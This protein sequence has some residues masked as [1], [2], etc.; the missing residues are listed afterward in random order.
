[1]PVTIE[2]T[3]Y[4]SPFLSKKKSNKMNVDCEEY[5]RK[6]LFIVGEIGDNDYAAPIFA[7]RSLKET[8]SYVPKII[9]TI[10]MATEVMVMKKEKKIVEVN[11]AIYVN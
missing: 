2:L 1:M 9:E 8:K 7:S 5:F 10:S 3:A 4:K 11:I 6:S